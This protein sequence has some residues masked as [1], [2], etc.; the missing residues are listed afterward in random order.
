MKTVFLATLGQRP[1]AITIALDRLRERYVYEA[2][3]LLHTEPQVSGVAQAFSALSHVLEH[4]YGRLPVHY[5]EITYAD[6]RPLLDL[7]DTFSV[8][9]YFDAVLTV[10]NDYK[11]TG[12]RIHLLVAGG[13]KAMSIYA[14]LAAARVFD[15]PHDR[16]WTV[17]SDPALVKQP[18]LYHVPAKWRNAI[19]VIDLPI[20]P[21]RLAPGVNPH[22]VP[23]MSRR[24]AFL[25]KLSDQEKVLVEELCQNPYATNLSLAKTLVKSNST[26]ENQF[27][28]IYAKLIGFLEFGETIPDSA[29]RLA[30][31][32]VVRKAD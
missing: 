22:T 2:F 27:S 10:L 17:L 3:G 4:D 8:N 32:D 23:V 19:Q 1:E 31:L 25:A 24:E 28:S 14:T 13:R 20:H 6:G 21:A 5:H 12:W 18:G 9:T 7:T 30:L 16:V 11:E 29:K 15:L 26:I